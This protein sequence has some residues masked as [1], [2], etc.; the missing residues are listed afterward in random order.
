MEKILRDSVFNA[1]I[2]KKEN[3]IF[4]GIFA[5][6]DGH[7]GYR[8]ILKAMWPMVLMLM[9]TSVYSIVDGWFI[10]NY[11]GSTAFAAMN[12]IWPALAIVSALGLMIGAGGSALVS[13][14]FGEE[15]P[16]KA[17]R[18]F[19]MLIRITF[20]VGVAI[21]VLLIILMKPLAVALGAE[22]EMIRPAVIYGIILTLAM[23]VYMLQ[24]AFQ[25]F[26]MT[27]EKPKLGTMTSIACGLANILLDFLFVAVF[28]WGLTGAAVATAASFLIGGVIPLVF[29][30][31]RRNDTVLRFV[32]GSRYDWHAVRQSCLNGLSEFV[33][34]IS[35]NIMAICYNLQLM[36]YIGENGVSA[37][38]ILMYVGF[39]FGSIFIGYN[40]GISQVIAFNYGAGNKAELRSMLKKSF[41]LIGIC[42]LAITLAVQLLASPLSRLFVGYDQELCALTEHALH[43]YMNSFLI[44]GFNMFASAWF[45]ALNN[46]PVSAAAAFTRT[47]VFELGCVFALPPI[48]G[49]D[50]IWMAVNFAEVLALILSL[51]LIFGFRKR[52]GY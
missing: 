42:S 26:F 29:F 15:N 39:I 7:Y 12:I 11:A 27:A 3:S 23:P 14:T 8:R 44:C 16:E 43:I 32:R 24:M 41:V 5:D 19:T 34:N 51:A 36:R 30:A 48:L 35:F 31:S 17:N 33:G 46:G 20:V 37:Y 52:Y 25:P 18:I 2:Y 1:Q 10:S 38:G 45:T 49:I 13:K 50:G 28:G 22:G 4:A 9:V 6:M 47:L 40:M 21:S